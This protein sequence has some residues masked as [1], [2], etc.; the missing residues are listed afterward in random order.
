VNRRESLV[1]LASLAVAGTGVA[2]PATARAAD[3]FPSR[4]IRVMVGYPPGSASENSLRALVKVAQK[5]LKVPLIIFNR[6]GA[7]QAIA[8]ATIAESS[9]D[10]YTIGMTTD[11]FISL[12]RHEQKLR[13]DPGVLLP[14]LAYAELQHVL[15]VRS[16]FPYPLYDDFVEQG[17]KPGA[18][19]TI[20]GT[21]QGTAPDLIARALIE[22]TKI[23]GTYIPFK[24]SSEYV[25]AVTGG[26][27]TAGL[28]DYSGIKGQVDAKAMKLV[29]VIG[30]R[31]LADLPDI[32]T[33]R[34]K[35]LIELDLLN[36]LRCMVIH[37][38]TP[39]DRLRLVQEAFI[40]AVNDPEF[41]N[42]AATSGL[43]ARNI[44]TRDIEER[45][46]KTEDFGIPLLKHM[47]SFVD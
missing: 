24:G 26:M 16:N 34:E 19:V 17:R 46:K 39:L 35:G 40:K 43:E 3:D 13:F 18:N 10:G 6:P 22:K 38:D 1:S 42:W 4:G 32:P 21:G 25:A 37:R 2:I 47:N 20:G 28:V 15:F 45:I 14:M 8:L 5:Y 27:L 11:T 7:N 23:D 36:P 9:A 33:S 44:P 41:R 31:R 30:D 29:L 12:T